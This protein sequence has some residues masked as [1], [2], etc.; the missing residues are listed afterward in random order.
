MSIK[1]VNIKEILPRAPINLIL[2][3]LRNYIIVDRE[4][5]GGAVSDSEVFL[6]LLEGV[7]QYFDFKE[8]SEFFNFE[9]TKN[10]LIEIGTY[11]GKWLQLEVLGHIF[12]KEVRKNQSEIEAAER[13]IAA[14]ACCDICLWWRGDPE[15]ASN[16]FTNLTGDCQKDMELIRN[17]AT[18]QKSRRRILTR[19]IRR[20]TG[21]HIP[22][23]AQFAKELVKGGFV[24]LNWEKKKDNIWREVIQGSADEGGYKEDL[25]DYKGIEGP[26][27]KFVCAILPISVV[28]LEIS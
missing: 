23:A 14:L 4:E 26:K 6:S 10:K 2:L 25:I 13:L 5:H 28:P 18:T 19:L 7:Y 8:V 12:Y 27:G 11:G 21:L 22:E 20:E 17:L 9:K 3:D 24:G 1:I 15:T 16:K